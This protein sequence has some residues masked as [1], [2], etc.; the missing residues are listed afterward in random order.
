MTGP[1]DAAQTE[2]RSARAETRRRRES[3]EPRAVF[4]ELRDCCGLMRKN[5]GLCPRA[6]G[7]LRFGPAAWCRGDFG[8]RATSGIGKGHITRLVF[9]GSCHWPKASH[10]GG[11]GAEP[12]EEGHIRPTDGTCFVRRAYR[13]LCRNSVMIPSSSSP[14]RLC[15]S[16]RDMIFSARRVCIDTAAKAVRDTHPTTA[17]TPIRCS[18]SLRHGLFGVPRLRGSNS[19]NVLRLPTVT[20]EESATPEHFQIRLKAGLQTGQPLTWAAETAYYARHFAVSRVRASLAPCGL[21]LVSCEE[22]SANAVCRCHPIVDTRSPLP[23]R[24]FVLQSFRTL[25]F[26]LDFRSYSTQVT[27]ITGIVSLAKTPRSQRGTAGRSCLL[28]VLCVLAR[29]LVLVAAEGRAGLFVL[30]VVKAP[31]FCLLIEEG[32]HEGPP[33]RCNPCGG[34]DLTRR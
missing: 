2:A 32:G 5:R 25:L 22:P 26:M 15:V 13:R 27:G 30:F 19:P 33:L 4:L 11:L 6:P 3:L 18:V 14:Q 21:S 12:P 24:A 17:P 10:A 28:G 9:S 34:R 20:R 1:A 23:W 7:I 31:G 8:L 16:A 29:E